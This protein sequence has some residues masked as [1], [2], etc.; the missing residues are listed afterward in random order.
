[1]EK[2][3]EHKNWTAADYPENINSGEYVRAKSIYHVWCCDC[4][5]FVNLLTGE[6]INDVGLVRDYR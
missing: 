3:C 1:M 5:N 4:K 6:V 2:L